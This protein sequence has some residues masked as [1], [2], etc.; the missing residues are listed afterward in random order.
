MLCTP[1]LSLQTQPCTLL[2]LALHAR[3]NISLYMSCLLTSSAP[4]SNP[5]NA[6][7]TCAAGHVL[8]M[9]T[10]AVIHCPLPKCTC[11]EHAHDVA[12]VWWGKQTV[13]LNII[14]LQGGD[15][16]KVHGIYFSKSL[17]CLILLLG[18]L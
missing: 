14:C 10:S 3:H 17:K 16:L 12:W 2:T 5:A 8:C 4:K 9:M 18:S 1:S 6:P 7:S 15:L 11:L 13:T